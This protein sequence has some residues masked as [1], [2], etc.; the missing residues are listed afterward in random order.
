MEW[1]I[2]VAMAHCL[3]LTGS[4]TELSERFVQSGSLHH[5]FLR[6]DWHGSRYYDRAYL[7]V[8]IPAPSAYK[9]QLDDCGMFVT[10][11]QY[12]AAIMPARQWA[13]YYRIEFDDCCDMDMIT[14]PRLDCQSPDVL[15][16]HS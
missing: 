16:S 10:T 9:K 8:C 15:L 14:R 6:W 4:N 3:P 11:V 5:G 2:F 7:A 1:G 13:R 12:Q